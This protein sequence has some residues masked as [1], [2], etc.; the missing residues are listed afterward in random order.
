MQRFPSRG[1]WDHDGGRE[2]VTR[3]AVDRPGRD[4]A[5]LL[6]NGTGGVMRGVDT[7]G[8]LTQSPA[9]GSPGRLRRATRGPVREGSV[10]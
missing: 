6:P 1:A 7:V 10:P 5:V 3:F 9:A 8:V 4:G 2:G